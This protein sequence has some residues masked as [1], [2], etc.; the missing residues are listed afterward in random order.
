MQHA[1]SSTRDLSSGRKHSLSR[2]RAGRKIR[3][4]PSLQ[5]FSFVHCKRSKSI[6][7]TDG[8]HP[9]ISP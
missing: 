5:I 9:F 2:C 6:S 4:L 7:P 1:T 8:N 3:G